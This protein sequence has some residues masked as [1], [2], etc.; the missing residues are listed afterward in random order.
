MYFWIAEDSQDLASYLHHDYW[1]WNRP[2]GVKVECN[3]SVRDNMFG[4]TAGHHL[5]QRLLLG[6]S[7]ASKLG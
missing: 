1:W 3:A 6:L 5:G 7:L 4:K 2:T